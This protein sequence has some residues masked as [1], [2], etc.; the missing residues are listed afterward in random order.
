[1]RFFNIAS[2]V[3]ILSA[4]AVAGLAF[5]TMPQAGQQAPNFTLPSQDGTPLTLNDL[6][7]KWVVLYF[8]PKDN[9]PGCTI[10]AH[11]FER[12]LPNYQ[13][14]NAMIVGVS[15]DTTGSHKDFCAKQGLTF[16]L[17]S[18]DQKKVVNEYGSTM[19]MAG[20]TL[21]SRN[22]FLIDPQ[23]KIAKVWVKV[24]PKTH[25]QDVLATLQSLEGKA[26]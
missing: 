6:R 7:G 9:T 4:S 19:G 24:D 16:K 5:D 15:V 21:A 26:Q 1:M 23:G 11:N 14:D 18:D 8:Y 12:D 25:S 13:R 20:M 22:T 17:L 2:L 3:F 10:E